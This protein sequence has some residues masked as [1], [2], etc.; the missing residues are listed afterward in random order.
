MALKKLA[1][2]MLAAMI[3]ILGFAPHEAQAVQGFG[4]EIVPVSP[5]NNTTISTST[6]TIQVNFSSPAGFDNVIVSISVDGK[7]Q[8]YNSTQTILTNHN[9]TYTV[10][11]KYPLLDGQHNVTVNVTDD[12]GVSAGLNWTFF[13]RTQGSAITAQ[14]ILWYVSLGVGLGLVA[15][16]VVLLYL[17]RTRNFSLRKHIRKFPIPKRVL[18]IGIPAVTAFFFVLIALSFFEGAPGITPFIT[19]YVLVI[20][21]FILLLPYSIYVQT[22]KKK[23]AEYERSFSQ[24]L[25]EMADAMRGGIDP[26]KAIIE[27]SKND[28]GILKK[29]L[30]IAANGLEMG[31]PFEEM[32]EA[33]VKPIDSKLIKRYASLIGESAKVGGEISQVVHRAAKDMDDLIKIDQDRSRSLSIQGTTIYISFG[34]LVVVIYLLINIYPSL[35]QA[36]LGNLFSGA[37][38]GLSSAS[39]SASSG[40]TAAAPMTYVTLKQRFLDLTIITGLGSGLIIGL[41]TN[42]KVKFGLIHGL[43]MMLAGMVFLI[44]MMG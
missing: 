38:G 25:Y 13:V 37:G 21:I 42:G 14:Q 11:S 4:P 20:G 41:F 28:T 2:L 31:R 40:S 12:A 5:S 18:Y 39:S 8:T 24:F 7:D 33:M 15:F 29:H 1:M 35:G 16:A 10:S 44:I 32:I 17:K 36:D 22:E 23:K 6:P 34:V 9:V 19:E 27:M 26:S 3:I 30:K 43:G